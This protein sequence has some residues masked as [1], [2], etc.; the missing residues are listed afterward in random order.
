[1]K[2]LFTGANG[3]LGKNVIPLLQKKNFEVKTFGTS[4]ADYIFNITQAITPFKEKFDIVFHAAGKAHS[5]PKTKEEESV[6]YKVNFEGTK[7][8]CNAL[9]ENLPE[10][11]VFI[12]TVAVYGK[13]FGENITEDTPLEG[14]TPY[15]K[16]KLMAEEFLTKWCKEKK[17]KLFILR[18]SLIAGP[19]PPGNLGDM[20]KAIKSGK[21][22]NIAGGTA[23]KSVF[24]VE[25]FAEITVKML[26]KE[27]GIYNV[28]DDANP[29]FKEISEKI[30]A[31]LNKRSP[32]S[33]PFFLAKSM[34]L[35]GDLLGNK[36]P[37][38][39]LKLKKITDSLIFSNEKIK[40]ELNYNPSNVI[41][42]FQL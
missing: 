4:N 35:V 29:A 40:R 36:A 31:K 3:F 41:E 15:A 26:G 1:M 17:V 30:S 33:I 7:K 38:N 34:A 23:R 37:I 13:D 27:G 28:C 20:I 12:S 16:S 19:N 22:F 42:K 21:Y 14:Y 2:V 8:L 39:S 9:E 32:K 10:Y 25:D 18:P 24:W 11:F 6:F 5:V